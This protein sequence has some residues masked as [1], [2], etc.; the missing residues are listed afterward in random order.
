MHNDDSN[1][2]HGTQDTGRRQTKQKI[3][4]RKLK[5]DEQYGPTKTGG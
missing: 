2:K 4:L 5:K 3:Q 1:W